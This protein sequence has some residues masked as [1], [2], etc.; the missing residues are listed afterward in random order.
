[1]HTHAA[2]S[3]QEV[4]YIKKKTEVGPVTWLIYLDLLGSDWVQAHLT[5]A[6]HLDL[7]IAVE[8]NIGYPHAASIYSRRGVYPKLG[9]AI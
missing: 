1:M 5:F 7:K 6:D 9:S 2:Q 8:H 4:N 3:P